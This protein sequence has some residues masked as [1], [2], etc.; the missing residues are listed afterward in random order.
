VST[1]R[2]A[3]ALLALFLLTLTP[4]GVAPA[5]AQEP[6]LRLVLAGQSP[7]T[8]TEEPV[9]RV[10]VLATN[11]GDQTLEDLSL[12][13]ALGSP[14]DS[15]FEYET[16]LSEG[17]ASIAGSVAVPLE[18]AIDPGQ[19]RTMRA[20]VDM[21]TIAAV[22]PDD[23]QVYPLQIEVR[24][25]DLPAG[26]LSSAAIHLVRVPEAPLLFSSWV[27]FASPSAFS[28]QG[29]FVDPS[30]EAALGT[31][32]S[33]GAPLAALRA[34][35]GEAPAP[36]IEVV[37][38]PSMLIDLQRMTGGYVRADGTEVAEG[39]GGAAAAAAFLD[40]LREVAADPSVQVVGLPYAGA[41]WPSLLG[42]G[43]DAEAR[44]QLVRGSQ[45]VNTVL[46]A[47]A[48]TDVARPTDGLLDDGAIRWLA[49]QGRTTVLADAD[50]VDRPVQD[51][52]LAPPPTATVDDADILGS[53]STLVLPDPGTDALLHRADLLADPLRGAQIVL[54]ELAVIWKEAPVPEPPTRR[55]LAVSLPPSLPPLVWEPLLGRLMRAPFLAPVHAQTLATDVQPPGSEGTLRAP[56]TAV[57][58]TTYADAVREARRDA[59]AYASMLVEE[60]EL[61]TQLRDAILR[62]LAA[63]YVG[64]EP[65]GSAWLEHVRSITERAFE[66][67]SPQVEQLFTFTSREGTIPLRLGDPGDVPLAVSIQ[68]QSS[69]FEFPNG[70]TQTVVLEGPNQIVTFDVVAR[71]S[72]RNPIRVVVSSPSGRAIDLQTIA[73][74]TT[75]VSG[76]ALGITVVAA[77][78]LVLLYTRRWWRRRRT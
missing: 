25:A 7:W 22:I 58:S 52:E 50:E 37:V 14:F 16:A 9:L 75:A 65:E 27:E 49:E 55:G 60:S 23:S 26:T 67:T 46:G 73:V 24:T 11:L 66:S 33:L 70:D 57:F 78:G 20:Q 8:T 28:P 76:I 59:N 31:E 56:D 3:R 74:Q 36:A 47:A 12:V 6:S 43:L 68:L 44:V 35:I 53:P 2:A 51:L 61:P 48:S 4:F 38:R 5:R 77:A 54:G 41:S 30:L 62:S 39:T 69:Q 34:A 13:V 64:N 63:E 40:V 1:P 19:T 72:G 18:G 71:A 45:T 29:E 32:G 17:P 21:S 42:S 15:R 10:A